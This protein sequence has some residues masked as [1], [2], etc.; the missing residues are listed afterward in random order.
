MIPFASNTFFCS[1]SATTTFWSLSLLSQI[2]AIRTVSLHAYRGAAG[3]QERIEKQLNDLTLEPFMGL[4]RLELLFFDY[5]SSPSSLALEVK[6]EY[7]HIM[8]VYMC[9]NGI[10]WVAA[11]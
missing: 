5:R 7:P 10:R 2:E 1:V 4:K 3:V 8:V 11:S 9:W 6:E